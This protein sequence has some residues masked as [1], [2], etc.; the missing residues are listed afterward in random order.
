VQS[1]GS[2]GGTSRLAASF[3]KGDV[4]T[5]KQCLNDRHGLWEVSGEKGRR[6]KCLFVDDD[7]D[8][9]ETDGAV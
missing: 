8:C 7:A 3:R 2:D 9:Q 5:L 4:V 6:A 1:D